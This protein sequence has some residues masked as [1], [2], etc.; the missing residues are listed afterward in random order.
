MAM[1]V[2]PADA[3]HRIKY[4]YDEEAT[5]VRNGHPYK[6]IVI[7]IMG[8]GELF[9]ASHARD[10]FGILDEYEASTNVFY[11]DLLMKDSYKGIAYCSV[12]DEFD[13]K[14]GM[15]IARGKLLNRYYKDEIIALN[16]VIK[17]IQK[18][19]NN[20]MRAKADIQKILDNHSN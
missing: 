20:A 8:D 7:A 4:L 11:R 12:D 9:H 16:K 13:L 15:R 1:K 18:N 10:V 17:G 2:I 19:L 6:G 5:G 3:N 14:E